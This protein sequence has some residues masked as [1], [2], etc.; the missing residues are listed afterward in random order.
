MPLHLRP[1]QS[2]TALSSSPTLAD[3]D[4][5]AEAV[6]SAMAQVYAAAHRLRS[7]FGLVQRVLGPQESYW[8]YFDPS[9]LADSVEQPIFHS[10]AV[11]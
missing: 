7:V 8:A 9:E 2:D 10:L 11:R 4:Q 6:L 5:W 1:Q 3:A